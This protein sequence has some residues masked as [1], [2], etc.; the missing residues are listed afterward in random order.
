M[1]VDADVLSQLRR[2]ALQ[3]G[4]SRADQ[5]GRVAPRQLLVL[6]THMQQV[7]AGSVTSA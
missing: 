4:G 3:D 1:A 7:I 6:V 5:S 2:G